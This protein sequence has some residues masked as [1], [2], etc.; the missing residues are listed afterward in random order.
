MA[1]HLTS[2]EDHFLLKP[3]LHIFVFPKTVST[4]PIVFVVQ[5]NDLEQNEAQSANGVMQNQ[6]SGEL[7]STQKT[8]HK[9]KNK[10]EQL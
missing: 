6:H 7:I 1:L 5:M 9:H 10:V 2:D 8:S 3:C 4:I